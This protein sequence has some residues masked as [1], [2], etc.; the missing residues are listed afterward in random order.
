MGRRVRSDDRALDWWILPFML[1]AAL[2]VFAA[3][4]FMG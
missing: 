2:L 4:R 1:L 3:L